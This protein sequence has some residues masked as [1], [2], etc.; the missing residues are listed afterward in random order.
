MKIIGL[1]GG[2]G[3]GK[4]TIAKMFE[5]LHIPVYYADIEA[6]KLM[7]TSVLIK[8]KLITLFGKK[9]F[10]EDKI[11]RSFIADVVFKDKEKL[12][13]LNEIVH[14][15]V[16]KNF[17][18]WVRRQDSF[19]VIQENAIIF[20]SKNQNNFDEIITVIAPELD[21]IKRVIK[22]DNVSEK[23]VRERMNNQL[24]D[25]YKIERSKYTIDNT[26]IK[27]SSKEVSR[28]HL[29]LSKK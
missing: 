12:Q 10:V 21:K 4:T 26:D 11:N 17:N 20:E 24:E 5:A 19:Y 15:E 14:P 16:D 2:I 9:A 29:E 28:I 27:E 3:S 7:N 23:M 18:D 8:S 22:R 25:T 6:K 1:T 13:K